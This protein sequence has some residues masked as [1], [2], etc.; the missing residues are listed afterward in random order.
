[1]LPHLFVGEHERPIVAI[2]WLTGAPDGR[3][4]FFRDPAT[5]GAGEPLPCGI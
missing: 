5:L 3:R 4:E 1:V 2:P